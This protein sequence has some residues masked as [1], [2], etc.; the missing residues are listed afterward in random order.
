MIRP[1]GTMGL[2]LPLFGAFSGLSVVRVEQPTTPSTNEERK[3]VATSRLT[4]HPAS[5]YIFSCH[6]YNSTLWVGIA[7]GGILL[8]RARPERISG[9]SEHGPLGDGREDPGDALQGGR[10][11]LNV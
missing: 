3:S 7:G 8:A 4:V 5:T 9:D 2:V 1:N 10:G 11:V 6:S